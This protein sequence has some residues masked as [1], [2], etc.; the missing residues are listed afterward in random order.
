MARSSSSQS[1]TQR[2][3]GSSARTSGKRGFASLSASERREVAARGGR[4]SHGGRDSSR[5]ENENSRERENGSESSSSSSRGRGRSLQAE[6][7]YR[8]QDTGRSG[9]G[10]GF[11]G[12][13]PE[14]RREIAARGGQHS[15]GGRNR[16]EDRDQPWREQRSDSGERSYRSRP[17]SDSGSGRGFASM[18]PERRREIASRGGQHS[19]GGQDRDW[20]EPRRSGQRGEGRQE[21]DDRYRYRGQGSAQGDFR[22]DRNDYD[23]PYYRGPNSGNG[24]SRGSRYEEENFRRDYEPGQ[25]VYRGQEEDY[26]GPSRD[27]YQGGRSF[28]D[29]PGNRQGSGQSRRNYPTNDWQSRHEGYGPQRTYGGDDEDDDSRSSSQS[30]GSQGRSSSQFGNR[31]DFDE[32][33]YQAR[34]DEEDYSSSSNRGGRSRNEEDDY[35]DTEE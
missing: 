29:N 2:R 19:H 4:A 5:G 28:A 12:M 1:S 14:R 17:G 13:D 35:E 24:P 18:D 8:A 33:D 23:D 6:N 32:D 21:Y 20:S 22:R 16:Y 31:D 15:Q 7:D 25:Q 27:A 3:Q 30:G 26:P 34:G 10:R 9:G 11:A